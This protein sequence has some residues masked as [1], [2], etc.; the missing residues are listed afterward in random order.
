MILAPHVLISFS[1]AIEDAV[2]TRFVTPLQQANALMT[3]TCAAAEQEAAGARLELEAEGK[4]TAQ[5]MSKKHKEAEKNASDVAFGD[6]LKIQQSLKQV[7]KRF[8]TAATTHLS[9][10]LKIRAVRRTAIVGNVLKLL[11]D[12]EA[13]LRKSVVRMEA[14]NGHVEQFGKTDLPAFVSAWEQ[15]ATSR[16]AAVG[17]VVREGLYGT[18][19]HMEGYLSVSNDGGKKF[20]RRYFVVSD[21]CL[22]QYPD[23]ANYR[24]EMNCDL[25][26]YSAKPL[27]DATAFELQSPMGSLLFEAPSEAKRNKWVAVVSENISNQLDAHKQTNKSTQ[28]DAKKKVVM[29]AVRAAPG[30]NVCADCDA[31]EPTWIS[32]NHGIVICHQ[33]SGV[34]RKIGTHLSKVRSLTLDVIDEELVDLMRA[35]GNEKA[36]TLL[37]AKLDRRKPTNGSKVSCKMMHDFGWPA[38]FLSKREVRDEFITDKYVNRAFA[39][40]S[41]CDAQTLASLLY[42]ILLAADVDPLDVLKHVLM[43]ANLKFRHPETGLT[44]LHALLENRRTDPFVLAQL[45][46][47]NDC[48]IDATAGPQQHRPLHLAARSNFLATCRVLLRNGADAT[49]TTTA[50]ETALDLLPLGEHPQKTGHPDIEAYLVPETR[51]RSRAQTASASLS[52][53]R[54]STPPVSGNLSGQQSPQ[55][56]SPTM[57][58]KATPARRLSFFGI[59]KQPGS[60]SASRKKA[61]SAEE[62]S[63]TV[64]DKV[65][66]RVSKSDIDPKRD[67][68]GKRRE[69]KGEI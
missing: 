40:A 69:S 27:S 21:G 37:E 32:L 11:P 2:R 17:R 19:R 39:A 55:L 34:H 36:N 26:L 51:R 18:S 8:E 31:V 4:K 9:S 59:K 56:D 47:F 66:K 20:V 7:E 6:L 5:Q 50:D 61:S 43:G 67:E 49:T 44:L 23:W 52:A 30:N 60:P 62:D 13:A 45:L 16:E 68:L 10:L 54:S 58:R 53:S 3:G 28:D 1:Q 15:E 12:V 33:C 29:D 35:I 48:V 25:L 63:D 57:G 64:L 14:S 38:N 24:V 65:K 46:V 42:D 41:D 22:V